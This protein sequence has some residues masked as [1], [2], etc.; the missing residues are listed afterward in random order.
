MEKRQAEAH[1]LCWLKKISGHFLHKN[2]LT[3]ECLWVPSSFS[4]GLRQKETTG[5]NKML[6]QQTPFCL[7]K[8]NENLHCLNSQICRKSPPKWK[9]NCF[10]YFR[11]NFTCFRWDKQIDIY[12]GGF[13]LWAEAHKDLRTL[14][15]STCG[16]VH[17]QEH[18]A[19]CFFHLQ[20]I[21]CFESLL[22]W[23]LNGFH[24]KRCNKMVLF[25]DSC[26]VKV[27]NFPII[28]GLSRR[29]SPGAGL[30]VKK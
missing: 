16:E 17:L 7:P 20:Q 5:S 8:K 14:H 24:V 23:T 10:L 29:E 6:H 12:L 28:F 30:Y 27:M 1:F 15:Y 3:T 21:P 18:V 19:P 2:D 11:S 26:L 9:K 13:S 4:S 22:S 25:D